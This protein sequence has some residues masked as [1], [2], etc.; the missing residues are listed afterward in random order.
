MDRFE[1]MMKE[2]KIMGLVRNLECA[3]SL[4]FLDRLEKNGKI[5]SDDK[6]RLK[7][8]IETKDRQPRDGNVA[9]RMRKQVGRLE[10]FDN[11]ESVW[12]KSKGHNTYY[13]QNNRDRRNT[14]KTQ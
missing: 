8:T 1:E 12:T 10:L 14:L 9:E 11:R 5:D 4:Q 3:L 13:V 6:H 7:D 2:T